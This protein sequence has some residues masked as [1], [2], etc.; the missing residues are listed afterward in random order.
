MGLGDITRQQVQAQPQGKT[1]CDDLDNDNGGNITPIGSESPVTTG[2]IWTMFRVTAI[3]RSPDFATS[4]AFFALTINEQLDELTRI[5]QDINRDVAG[6]V[7]KNPG[8]G[9]ILDPLI[10]QPVDERAL[11]FKDTGRGNSEFVMS[12]NDP[13]QQTNNAAA[14]AAAALASEQAA[15]ISE[16]NAGNSETNAA[17]SETAA[18]VSEGNA[19]QSASDAADSATAASEQLEGTSATSLLIETGVK[20]FTT[21]ADKFF[22]AGVSLK[23]TSD[24]DPANF[25]FGDVTSYSGTTLTMNITAIEG[26]GTFADW[27]IRLSGVQGPAQDPTFLVVTGS[28]IPFAGGAAPAGYLLCNGATGLDSV[29]DTTL[30]ALFAVIGTTYGGTGADDFDLPSM[31]DRVAIG[32]GSTYTLGVLGGSTI[33][34]AHVM[35]VAELAAHN[36]TYTRTNLGG[37]GDDDTNQLLV[38]GQS[39]VATST[40]GSNSGHTHTGNVPPFNPVLW[41]IKK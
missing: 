12:D 23:I 33:T 41:I 19:A 35:S 27:T 31:V 39:T 28:I 1:K 17:N 16:T 5:A 32:A 9:D 36:H 29:A 2:D 6:V 34:D 38:T 40:T 14:S 26:S 18:G 11:K 7:R 4:G 10:P 3:D 37:A 24:A 22:E 8:V 30:A 21:Q 20:V 25:M 13:D 15:A